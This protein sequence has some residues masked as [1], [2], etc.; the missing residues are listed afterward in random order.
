MLKQTAVIFADSPE[1][2][3]TPSLVGQYLHNYTLTFKQILLCLQALSFH[4]SVFAGVR[5]FHAPM[6][7]VILAFVVPPASNSHSLLVA[8]PPLC[9]G[10]GLNSNLMLES[11]TLTPY[12]YTFLKT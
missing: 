3:H 11:H 1:L 7:K 8:S 4:V 6:L 10:G 9:S 12:L 2:C 5:Y